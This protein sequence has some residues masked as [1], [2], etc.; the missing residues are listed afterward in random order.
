MATFMAPATGWAHY[1]H[2]WIVAALVSASLPSSADF[3]LAL[4]A[5]GVLAVAA[6]A[7]AYLT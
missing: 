2:A 1:L 4:P 7:Y 5:L 3:K 6:L